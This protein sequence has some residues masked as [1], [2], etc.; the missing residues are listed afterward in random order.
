MTLKQR[1]Q[2]ASD[3]GSALIGIFIGLPAFQATEAIAGSGF[4]FFIFDSEHSP[5]SLPALHAQLTALSRGS[6]I[7][8][9]RVPSNHAVSIKHIL[10]LGV[11]AVMVP[12]VR[13]PEQAEAAVRAM[14]YPPRGIRG[15]G[16]SIRATDFGRDGG[17]YSRSSKN[18]CLIVQ[19]ESVEGFDNLEAI[20]EV[21]G[22]DVLFFGPYD[23]A[24]DAGY[25]AEPGHP[26]IAK[27]I[28]AGVATVRSCGKWAGLLTAPAQ[29]EHYAKQGATLISISSDVALL[30]KASDALAREHKSGYQSRSPKSE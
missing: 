26:K 4:D 7:P 17:Y 15:M 23:L 20:C 5:S 12:D 6:T 8:I 21:D 16:G 9:V 28:E 24:A 13:T 14:H 30:V 19:I 27:K 22:V 25:L 18:V 29:R 2:Q 10:D 3:E 11:D 1:L